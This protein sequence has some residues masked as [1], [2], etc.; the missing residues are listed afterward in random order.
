MESSSQPATFLRECILLV[1][2]EL[3]RGKIGCRALFENS[4]RNV[5][6]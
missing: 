3:W 1:L 5:C 6:D 4:D 2:V